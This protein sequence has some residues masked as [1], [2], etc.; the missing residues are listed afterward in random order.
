MGG[1][2]QIM[3]LNPF[4]G[5]DLYECDANAVVVAAGRVAVDLFQATPP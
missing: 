5:S 2:L 4:S 1:S 3:E